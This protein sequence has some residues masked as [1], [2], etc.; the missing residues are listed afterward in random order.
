MY[1]RSI[2]LSFAL[3]LASC[4]IGV[5]QSQ[6]IGNTSGH[7]ENCFNRTFCSTG[8]AP[9]FIVLPRGHDRSSSKDLGLQFDDHCTVRWFK[10]D[11]AINKTY[12][13]ED[14]TVY[15]EDLSDSEP[16]PESKYSLSQDGQTLTSFENSEFIYTPEACK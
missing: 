6:A 4:A 9:K 15:I 13:I 3:I 11:M 5:K 14:S 2:F 10:S 7:K 12:R 16:S 8:K 1:L